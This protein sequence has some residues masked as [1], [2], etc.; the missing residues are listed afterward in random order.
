MAKSAGRMGP[1]CLSLLFLPNLPTG[2]AKKNEGGHTLELMGW[3]RK[4]EMVSKRFQS[5]VNVT[6][7]M[8]TWRPCKAGT[9]LEESSAEEMGSEL[10]PEG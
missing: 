5:A 2:S 3:T 6:D 10:V 8:R 4:P 9:L 1:S 7:E